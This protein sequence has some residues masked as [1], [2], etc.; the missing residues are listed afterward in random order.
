M[1]PDSSLKAPGPR[2]ACNP[3]VYVDTGLPELLRRLEASGAAKRRLRWTIAGGAS[4]M[5]DSAS[6]RIGKRNYLAV[7]NA[8]WHLGIFIENEDVGGTESRSV[9]LDLSTGRVDVRTGAGTT[10]ILTPAFNLH[11]R[12]GLRR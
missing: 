4:M 11:S 6:L 3:F 10:Q 2:A 7:V 12:E 9:K 1:M 8:C 5:A